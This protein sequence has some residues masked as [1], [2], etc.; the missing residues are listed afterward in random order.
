MGVACQDYPELGVFSRNC[1]FLLTVANFTVASQLTSERSGTNLTVRS[2]VVRH[3]ERCFTGHAAS[4]TVHA[5]G[6]RH[7]T[8][9][10]ASVSMTFFGSD[11]EAK[12][13]L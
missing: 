11:A 9:N 3:T 2:S 12:A 1:P 5:N 13:K 4:L 7:Y 10:S 6:T 8:E